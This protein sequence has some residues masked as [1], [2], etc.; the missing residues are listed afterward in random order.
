MNQEMTRF[1]AHFTFQEGIYTCGDGGGYARISPE[2]T[3][4]HT[5][6]HSCVEHSNIV[7]L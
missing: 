3:H 1:E 2:P 7:G 4:T 6:H 5:H